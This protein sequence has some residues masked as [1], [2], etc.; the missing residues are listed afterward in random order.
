MLIWFAGA[1]VLLT[2]ISGNEPV[3]DET[4]SPPAGDPTQEPVVATAT[5][6]P[7]QELKLI[8]QVL[9]E[10]L[11]DA[12]PLL[13]VQMP[14]I[15]GAEPGSGANSYNQFV[16]GVIQG[17]EEAFK[18][19]MNSNPPLTPVGPS[20]YLNGYTVA[21]ATQSLISLEI[22]VSAYLGGAVH[23]FPYT[24]SVNYDLTKS[25]PIE[26]E[27]LFLAGSDYLNRLADLSKADLQ[28]RDLLFFEEGVEPTR[29]NFQTWTMSKDGLTLIFD[30]YQ[31]APYAAGRQSVTIPFAQLSDILDPNALTG[32]DAAMLPA[33]PGEMPV[34]FPTD[35]NS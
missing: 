16:Q 34:R 10:Q 7:T 28:S 6:T 30:V 1:C 33:N 24:I 35:T 8:P 26:L 13:S 22:N 27:G 20:S 29:E 11:G 19:N 3:E 17:D 15:Q 21:T 25:Q 12:D 5:V 14:V 4:P 23:P 9:D 18:V 31:V 32:L 2:P